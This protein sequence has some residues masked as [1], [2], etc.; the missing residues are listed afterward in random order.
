[1]EELISRVAAAAGV[2]AAVAQK[3]IAIILQFLEKEGPKGEV[4]DMINAIP[5]AREAMSAEA[6]A[7]PRNPGFL[8]GLMGA[9][10]GGSGLMALAGKLSSAGLDMNQMKS[11][12]KELFAYAKEHVPEEEMKAI[13]AKTPGFSQLL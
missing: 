1:M 3:A 4:A 11:V 2:N 9:L 13:A 5:G 10:G 7:P 12:G 6:A 8:G